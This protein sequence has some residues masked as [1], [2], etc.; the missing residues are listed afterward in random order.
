MILLAA[1]GLLAAGPADGW[2][3]LALTRYGFV[4]QVTGT[5]HESSQTVQTKAGPGVIRSWTA[6]LEGDRA[7]TI[8]VS[9]LARVAGKTADQLLDVSVDGTA[10]AVD[11]TIE[12]RSPLTVAG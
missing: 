12:S 9:E 1:L 2:H 11:A 8:N 10:S 3:E 4:V 6:Q 5:A 7:L